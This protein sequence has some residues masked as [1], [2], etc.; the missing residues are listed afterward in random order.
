MSQ[1]L[2]YTFAISAQLFPASLIVLSLC[3]SAAVQGVLVRLFF[4]GGCIDDDEEAMP[5]SS[6]LKDDSLALAMPVPN[7]LVPARADGPLFR[8]PVED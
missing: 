8:G 4:A 7:A 1:N 6:M 2:L 5:C 3:S